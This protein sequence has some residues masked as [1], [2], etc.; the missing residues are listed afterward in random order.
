[1]NKTS[2]R[3]ILHLYTDKKEDPPCQ[4]LCSGYGLPYGTIVSNSPL[5]SPE[6]VQRLCEL[7]NMLLALRLNPDAGV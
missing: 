6:P 4:T 2:P 1:M 5:E 3:A 7:E